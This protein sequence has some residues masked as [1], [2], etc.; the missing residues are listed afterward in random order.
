MQGLSCKSVGKCT[1]SCSRKQGHF[2]SITLLP[3]DVSMVYQCYNVSI[4]L[5]LQRSV[6]AAADVLPVNRKG[7]NV[8]KGA[9]ANKKLSD[10]PNPDTIIDISSDDE[11]EIV[12]KKVG[13]E[14]QTSDEPK[15]DSNIQINSNDEKSVN[16]VIERRSSRN[17][18]KTLSSILTARSKV[19]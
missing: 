13:I 15:P 4:T 3:F 9:L 5:N 11:E 1:K 10:K 14:K 12:K 18:V 17:N 6:A 19:I 8:K 2:P 7:G 16:P